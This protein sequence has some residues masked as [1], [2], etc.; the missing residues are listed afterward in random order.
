MYQVHTKPI[1]EIVPVRG[2]DY[3]VLRWSPSEGADGAQNM[4]PQA[5]PSPQPPLVMMHGWMD[6][7]ASFQFVADAFSMAFRQGRTLIAPS[8]RGFGLSESAQ[9][10]FWFPDYLADLE[11]LLDHYAP[12]TAVD[13]LGH[14]MGGNVVMMYAGIRP[15]RIRK[16]IN[17]EGFGMPANTPE[18]APQRYA[19]WLHELQRVRQGEMALKTYDNAQGVARRLMKTNPRLPEDKALWLA[20]QWARPIAA[21]PQAGQWEILGSAAHKVVSAQLYRV[22]EVLEIWKQIVA[23]LLM[24]QASENEMSTWWKDRYTQAEFDQRIQVVPQVQHAKIDPAGHMLHH[25]QP[26]Q[27]ATL[28][29]DFL[30]A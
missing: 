19:Q 1:S 17:L 13:L 23:P 6:V 30:L 29:E 18:Q 22:E 15:E 27:L 16:L 24:V 3:H 28:I 4:V 20:H 10:H 21:G 14:S 11:V 8:W 2:I 26:Q 5:K 12:N 25:D 9:E 7:G